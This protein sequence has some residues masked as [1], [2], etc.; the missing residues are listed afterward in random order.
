MVHSLSGGLATRRQALAA[1]ACAGVS[2]AW[3]APRLP[4]ITLAGPP[5]IVSAPL[6]HMAETGALSGVSERTDFT[7]W[8]DQIGRAHV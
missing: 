4:R 7:A 8:R 2:A 3:A 5:A 1:L 6:I